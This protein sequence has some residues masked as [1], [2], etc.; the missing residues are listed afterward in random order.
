MFHTIRHWCLAA[1]V[2][3]EHLPAGEGRRPVLR[4]SELG[5]RLLADAGWDP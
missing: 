2:I 4:P 3:E 5:T 1:E